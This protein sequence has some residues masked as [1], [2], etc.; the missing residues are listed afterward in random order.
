MVSS[1]SLAS[2]SYITVVDTST[3][4]S[5]A[6]IWEEGRGRCEIYSSHGSSRVL[7]LDRL[8]PSR[9]CSIVEKRI[10]VQVVD[11][12]IPLGREPNFSFDHRATIFL[13]VHAVLN[14]DYQGHFSNTV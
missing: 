12:N 6:L 8:D 9:S 7:L 5:R 1:N 4:K 13:A 11:E 2:P 10:L 3:G 14:Y